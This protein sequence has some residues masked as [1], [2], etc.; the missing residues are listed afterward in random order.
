MGSHALADFAIGVKVEERPFPLAGAPLAVKADRA[1]RIPFGPG[2]LGSAIDHL[3]ACLAGTIGIGVE[4]RPGKGH[5]AKQPPAALLLQV[6]KARVC[7]GFGGRERRGI[8]GPEAL[9]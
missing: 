6:C 7:R 1:V 9:D 8:F 3:G 4:R 2:A 5:A